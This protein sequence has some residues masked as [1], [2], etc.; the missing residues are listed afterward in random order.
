[1]LVMQRG[2]K[3]TV[4]RGLGATRGRPLRPMRGF[5]DD[6]S[7]PTT[8]PMSADGGETI[9]SDIYDLLYPANGD[10]DVYNSDV[11]EGYG[12]MYLQ[13]TRRMSGL[14]AHHMHHMHGAS[15]HMRFGQTDQTQVSTAS[16]LTTDNTTKYLKYAAIAGAAFFAW[17]YFIKK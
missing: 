12:R 2:N 9:P 5:G 17:K 14:G 10:D 13:P 8:D 7:V 11:Y 1:M 3:T 4:L 16:V 6:V 15:G